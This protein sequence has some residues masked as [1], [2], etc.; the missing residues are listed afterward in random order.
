MR[1]GGIAWTQRS[2]WDGR[3][4]RAI[5]LERSPALASFATVWIDLGRPAAYRVCEQVATLHEHGRS[6]PMSPEHREKLAEVTRT[7]QSA[8]LRRLM[9]MIDTMD[10]EDW[11]VYAL[12]IMTEDNASLRRDLLSK[13]PQMPP[14]VVITGTFEIRA[15]TEKA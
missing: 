2:N 10:F 9:Q 13:D 14:R 15:D 5:D 7:T 8:L 11:V 3:E 4:F 6:M 12:K 1:N